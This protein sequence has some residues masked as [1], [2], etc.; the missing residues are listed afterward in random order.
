MDGK[1]IGKYMKYK[2]KYLL[3]TD[4]KL[5]LYGYGEWIEEPDQVFFEYRGMK[6][7]ILR[8]EHTGNLCGYIC[9]NGN[10]PFTHLDLAL[11]IPIDTHGGITY[12]QNEEDGY[13]IGFDCAHCGDFCPGIVKSYE[14]MNQI[15]RDITPESNIFDRMMRRFSEDRQYKNIQFCI[16]E[17]KR[18]VDQFLTLESKREN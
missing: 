1:H 9:V 11:D 13:W 14:Y 15:L 18:M 6:C 16:D 8:C 2:N 7:K 17:C 4:E 10:H 12:A 3:T 5:R